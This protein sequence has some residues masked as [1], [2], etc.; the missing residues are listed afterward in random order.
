MGEIL[1][2]V[3]SKVAD[4]ATFKTLDD[5]K[6]LLRQFL[7]LKLLIEQEHPYATVRVDIRETVNEANL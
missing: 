4:T 7:N 5:R 1:L 3:D 6:L 2:V